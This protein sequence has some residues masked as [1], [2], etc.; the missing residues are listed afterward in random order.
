MISISTESVL[1]GL[2]A[3]ISCIV[4]MFKMLQNSHVREI[5]ACARELE[6]LRHAKDETIR[7]KDETILWLKEEVRL[8]L[9]TTERATVAAE[10]ATTVAR[11]A[12]KE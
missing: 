11:E 8:S 10:S 9:R 6:T 1:A 4:F 2:T 3:L 7:E 5:A 12:K